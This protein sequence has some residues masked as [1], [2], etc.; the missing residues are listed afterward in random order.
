VNGNA[1]THINGGFSGAFV[2]GSNYHRLDAVL[3]T[4]GLLSGTGVHG[5]FFSGLAGLQLVSA[6][7][8]PASLTLLAAGIG[9]LVTLRRRK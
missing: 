2:E 5:S 8:E 3:V 1:F 9:L 6:V 7:P 4:G